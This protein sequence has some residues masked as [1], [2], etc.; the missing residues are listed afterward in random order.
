MREGVRERVC[1]SVCV[2]EGERSS[3]QVLVSAKLILASVYATRFVKIWHL[4]PEST[5]YKDK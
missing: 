5:E 1:E 3:T 4:I 2:R